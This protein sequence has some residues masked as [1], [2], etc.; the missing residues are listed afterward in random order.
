MRVTTVAALICDLR[1][2]IKTPQSIQRVR[3]VCPQGKHEYNIVTK[4]GTLK[5]RASWPWFTGHV[6]HRAQAQ[7]KSSSPCCLLTKPNKVSSPVRL[8]C[9]YSLLGESMST[10]P[11]LLAAPLPIGVSR[12][13]KYTSMSSITISWWFEKTQKCTTALVKHGLEQN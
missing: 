2:F 10:D 7:D 1:P 11:F 8:V 4:V 6:A 5:Q 9:P 13:H 12:H 3:L